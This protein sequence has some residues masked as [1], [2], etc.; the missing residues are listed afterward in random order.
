MKAAPNKKHPSTM[1]YGRGAFYINSSGPGAEKVH[2]LCV[3][4]DMSILKDG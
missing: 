3:L 2:L 4:R 1:K